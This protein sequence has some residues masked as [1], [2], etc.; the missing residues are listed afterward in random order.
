MQQKSHI[1]KRQQLISLFLEEGI[2][3]PSVELNNWIQLKLSQPIIV[4]TSAETKTPGVCN[5]KI[6]PESFI[7]DS[8]PVIFKFH[9]QYSIFNIQHSILK[10]NIQIQYSNSVFNIKIKNSNST[11]KVN[12]QYSTFNIQYS[13]FNSF[14]SNW[15]PL[16]FKLQLQRLEFNPSLSFSG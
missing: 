3:P 14:M 10:F 9:N 8:A 12:I 11:F 5:L 4:S 1:L 13:I 7:S 15:Y 2:L 6:Y 16:K